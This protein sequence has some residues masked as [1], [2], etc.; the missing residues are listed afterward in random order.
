MSYTVQRRFGL[1]PTHQDTSYCRSLTSVAC[2]SRPCVVPPH[3]Q[4]PSP[5]RLKAVVA[6]SKGRRI[7]ACGVIYGLGLLVL[8]V[9]FTAP[10]YFALML[11]MLALGFGALFLAEKLR[12]AT[13]T[14]IIMTQDTISTSD[15]VVLA[16]IDQIISVDRGS[17]PSRL[18][19]GSPPA[20]LVDQHSAV[21]G[22]PFGSDM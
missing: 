22:S 21:S 3:P 6:A 13:L 20:T 4:V 2:P 1:K 15:G 17:W 16:Q 7:L 12:R 5:I 14:Q 19:C 10:P 9:T 8:Y 11:F 18:P